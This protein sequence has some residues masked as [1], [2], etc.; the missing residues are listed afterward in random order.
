MHW[1]D[2]KKL[3][4]WILQ[5]QDTDC[6]GLL[7]SD[8]ALVVEAQTPTEKDDDEVVKVKKTASSLKKRVW[9][10][11]AAQP[12]FALDFDYVDINDYPDLVEQAAK[13]EREDAA[14]A[15]VQQI[16]DNLLAAGYDPAA[17]CVTRDPVTGLV[18]DVSVVPR[19][20][21]VAMSEQ[22]TAATDASRENAE[23]GRD[24]V[25]VLPP[26]TPIGRASQTRIL[27]QE[28][29][30][31][32]VLLKSEQ[33]G[34]KN[35]NATSA[36]ASTTDDVAYIVDGQVMRKLIAQAKA[37]ST[38]APVRKSHYDADAPENAVKNGKK[39]AVARKVTDR[40]G[41]VSQNIK[42]GEA[43]RGAA[44]T[45]RNRAPVSSGGKK[46]VGPDGKA[47]PQ[48]GAFTVADAK[49]K[50]VQNKI[51][52]PY[53]LAPYDKTVTDRS[54][55]FPLRPTK[56]VVRPKKQGANNRKKSDED[57]RIRG[58]KHLTLADAR[59][60]Q[61][62]AGRPTEMDMP[63]D[64]YPWTSA[65]TRRDAKPRF[66]PEFVMVDKDSSKAVAEKSTEMISQPGEQELPM[67]VI[68]GTDADEDSPSPKCADRK[69]PREYWQEKLGADLPSGFFVEPKEKFEK[70]DRFFVF[71]GVV[72]NGGRG[73][74]VAWR[75][76]LRGLGEEGA[77]GGPD[78]Q[79]IG[80]EFGDLETLPVGTTGLTDLEV[81]GDGEGTQ[82]DNDVQPAK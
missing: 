16:M 39:Q 36:A 33:V 50:A 27:L 57:K 62:L 21:E 15:E 14:A 80:E 46:I 34:G 47:A 7:D 45:A 1:I 2:F 73:D 37:R 10:S 76:S 54:S 32:D 75:D 43:N 31:E 65:S 3:G 53:P 44:S 13:E 66:V 35:A 60:V 72:G 17:I 29:E 77:G 82:K 40:A 67:N 24:E 4:N 26:S 71:G 58:R 25:D 5:C 9:N 22:Q 48:G 30:I 51:E 8:G 19:E 20:Q 38:S 6:G 41:A 69:M 79:F 74:D 42:V 78:F 12:P 55:K 49:K 56:R 59:Q 63:G 70:V 52:S 81:E 11:E 28:D 68:V 18:T 64:V 23:A 61:G